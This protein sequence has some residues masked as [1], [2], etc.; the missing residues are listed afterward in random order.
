M[1]GWLGELDLLYLVNY[2]RYLNYYEL[3]GIY[4]V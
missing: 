3:Q 1:E 2:G 4:L